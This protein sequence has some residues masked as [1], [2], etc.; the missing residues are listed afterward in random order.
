MSRKRPKSVF[1]MER[2]RTACVGVEKLK[3]GAPRGRPEG[4]S[5]VTQP[6]SPGPFAP[7]SVVAKQIQQLNAV[8]LHGY[9]Q[10]TGRMPAKIARPVSASVYLAPMHSAAGAGAAAARAAA[11]RARPERSPEKKRARTAGDASP[12]ALVRRGS[13]DA[14]D[15][16]SRREAALARGDRSA[17]AARAAAAPPQDWEAAAAAL[18]AAREMFSAAARDD[19]RA[20]EA[21]AALS[22][23]RADAAMR[24]VQQ[25][26]VERRGR[27]L[28]L[29]AANKAA[30]AAGD[31]DRVHD[32]LSWAR[33]EAADEGEKGGAG[34]RANAK[35]WALEDGERLR[36]EA[37]AAV[38]RARWAQ[39]R[40]LLEAAAQCFA[41]AKARDLLE[42]AAQCFAWA[43]ARDLLEAAAQCFAWAKAAAQCF[44]WAKAAAQC[45]AWVKA[46]SA[47]A[48]HPGGAQRLS[49]MRRGQY[50]GAARR[51]ESA[52]AAAAP[53][54]DPDFQ[55]TAARFAF[56]MTLY[57][58]ASKQAADVAA[59]Q[60]RVA[61]LQNVSEGQALLDRAAA[62]A[63]LLP[64]ADAIGS[65][66]GGS[67]PDGGGGGGA[68]RLL[69]RAAAAYGTAGDGEGV[70]RFVDARLRTPS[71]A[72]NDGVDRALNMPLP[73]T[74]RAAPSYVA[75]PHCAAA[76]TSGITLSHPPPPPPLPPPLPAASAVRAAER[77]FAAV[78]AALAQRDYRACLAHVELAHASLDHAVR[79]LPCQSP[80]LEHLLGLLS[81][82]LH[83][84]RP[85]PSELVCELALQDGAAAKESPTLHP[86][87]PLPS[88]LVCE[89]AL[90][91]G[92]VA[93]DSEL[94]CELAL[95]DR[96]AAA[97]AEGRL[98]DAARDAAAAT[99]CLAWCAANALHPRPYAPPPLPLLRHAWGLEPPP[100]RTPG[101]AP[102]PPQSPSGGTPAA[103]AAALAAA[104]VTA[105]GLDY[106][107]DEQAAAARAA[108]RRLVRVAA[109][110]AAGATAAAAAGRRGAAAPQGGGALAGVGGG[111]GAR[112]VGAELQ[113]R[114]QALLREMAGV[115][116]EIAQRSALCEADAL[117]EQCSA[118]GGMPRGANPSAADSAAVTAMLEEAER[119][120]ERHGLAH[121]AR[122]AARLR[123]AVGGGACME[124]ARRA[125][126][127]GRAAEALEALAEAEAAYTRAGDAAAA[128]RAVQIALKPAAAAAALHVAGAA[129]AA[130]VRGKRGDMALEGVEAAC[131]ALRFDDALA[132]MEDARALY[133]QALPLPEALDALRALARPADVLRRRA[134]G[135]GAAAKAS[136][137]LALRGDGGGDGGGGGNRAATAAALR[138]RTSPLR[139]TARV[140]AAVRMVEGLREGDC[141]LAQFKED[142]RAGAARQNRGLLLHAERCY[143]DAKTAYEELV[144]RATELMA[145]E[146]GGMRLGLALQD[147]I[148]A[149]YTPLSDLSRAAF[150]EN[151]LAI[152]DAD[153]AIVSA[154]PLVERRLFADA[155]AT[156]AVAAGT[157]RRGVASHGGGAGARLARV[158]RLAAVLLDSTSDPHHL[159]DC[160]R[161]AAGI[162]DISLF[163]ALNGVD[164]AAGG[165]AP[166]AGDSDACSA[167][168]STVASRASECISHGAS[169]C[170]VGELASA[171]AAQVL[172]TSKTAADSTGVD[173]PTHEVPEPLRAVGDLASDARGASFATDDVLPG[174]D[175]H[176]AESAGDLPGTVDAKVLRH[177]ADAGVTAPR[178]SRGSGDYVPDYDAELSEAAA[179]P[180]DPPPEYA[181]S[182]AGAAADAAFHASSADVMASGEHAGSTLN[183]ATA[184][185]ARGSSFGRPARDAS[186]SAQHAGS[187]NAAAAQEGAD[188]PDAYAFEDDMETDAAQRS[189]SAAPYGPPMSGATVDDG[190]A[191]LEGPESSAEPATTT[192]SSNAVTAARVSGHALHGTSSD[193]ASALGTGQQSIVVASSAL[194]REST[195]KRNSA[196]AD[197]RHRA[198]R[199]SSSMAPSAKQRGTRS[200]ASIGIGRLN[201]DQLSDPQ[202]YDALDDGAR[203]PQQSMAGDAAGVEG[204]A[205]VSDYLA[206]V[207]RRLHTGAD[208]DDGDAALERV[209]EDNVQGE[210]A[211]PAA[212]E[213]G[214]DRAQAAATMACGAGYDDDSDPPPPQLMRLEAAESRGMPSTAMATEPEQACTTDSDAD[215]MQAGA[216]EGSTAE[217]AEAAAAHMDGD[218]NWWQ[219]VYHTA[220]TS[221]PPDT[222]AAAAA[223]ARLRS[224]DGA[225]VDATAAAPVASAEPPSDGGCTPSAG[226][227]AAAPAAPA[228]SR[229]GDGWWQQVYHAARESNAPGAA[230]APPSLRMS[231]GALAPSAAPTVPVPPDAAEQEDGGSWWQQVYH[232][233][234]NLRQ[235]LSA[236][237]TAEL[238]SSAVG[239]SVGASA[240]ATSDLT[241]LQEH[242]AATAPPPPD[243]GE[244]PG[245]SDGSSS[246]WQQVY[247]AER[248]SQLHTGPAPR[249]SASARLSDGAPVSTAAALAAAPEAAAE[250]QEGPSM[251]PPAAS[252]IAQ[253]E[254]DGSWWQ[255]VY[256]TERQ[257]RL[258]RTRS[259]P[260]T[261]SAR[262]SA[263]A[264][265]DASTA[266]PAA[267]ESATAQGDD[268]P[269]MM[270][271]APD[272]AQLQE[273][274]ASAWWQQVYHAERQSQLPR[275]GP[276][277][278]QSG[279]AR[280]A[281]GADVDVV[282]PAPAAAAP[283]E[284]ERD[285]GWR[286]QVYHSAQDSSAAASALTTA[287]APP[288]LA[289]A[290]PS[291]GW[292]QQVYDTA[293]TPSLPA[294]ASTSVQIQ[295]S[296][297][298]ADPTV[299][300]STLAGPDA[301]AA[302]TRPSDT[303]PSDATTA[304]PLVSA[305]SHGVD[306]DGH[307]ARQPAPVDAESF[308]AQRSS[309]IKA[310]A[311]DITA[312][313]TG[314]PGT[315]DSGGSWWN[316]VYHAALPASASDGA[317]TGAAAPDRREAA[318]A[319]IP[320]AARESYTSLPP[321]DV[322][323]QEGQWWNDVCQQVRRSSEASVAPFNAELL[324]AVRASGSA[325]STA[326]T[327][328]DVA[329]SAQ[330]SEALGSSSA[331][332]RMASDAH[333][334]AGSVSSG[335]PAEHRHITTQHAPAA[336]ASG[337]GA[338]GGRQS[339]W[340]EQLYATAAPLQAGNRLSTDTISGSTQPRTS[341]GRASVSGP[342]AASAVDAPSALYH[343]HAP[344]S[345]YAT[346]AAAFTA[347]DIEVSLT[348]RALRTEAPAHSA[349]GAP[350]ATVEVAAVVAE[351]ALAAAAGAAPQMA[352]HGADNSGN[353]W[354]Q[355][356]DGVVPTP[357]VPDSAADLA[358][359]SVEVGGTPAVQHLTSAAAE[360]TRRDSLP[361]MPVAQAVDAA[362]GERRSSWWQAVYQQ[363]AA[364]SDS[365]AQRRDSWWNTVYQQSAAAAAAAALE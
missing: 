330:V 298:A 200:S 229:G 364:G 131:A 263:G 339:L 192:L 182:A 250:L 305:Q 47:R 103:A 145:D 268:A 64:A 142:A 313:D 46:S 202:D 186:G 164:A 306:A 267:R 187:A 137:L 26:L 294:A 1:M 181:P 190:A 189:D 286:Q 133:L 111:G 326:A 270:P 78:A 195:A 113:A 116:E 163:T 50:A 13:A 275:T 55:C 208:H 205:D 318:A 274:G 255:Q 277:P 291:G 165:S 89:L 138:R 82:T 356:Y 132:A 321:P 299:R 52:S 57:V 315:G 92:A 346:A 53:E 153:A 86:D 310:P 348:P 196:A 14:V 34:G 242:P 296:D 36:E 300:N 38:A 141:V 343:A 287:P 59:L 87:R 175:L 121:A 71:V 73:P 361:G 261:A 67:A 176:G 276:A 358:S 247:H 215:A 336:A 253:A 167:T 139:S 69:Q 102:S 334:A 84:D 43:K 158:E 271:A 194:A 360:G 129:A 20:A 124:T 58:V 77:C 207:T 331:Y 146:R 338:G 30:R 251:L 281:D 301:T 76:A 93:K 204:G 152:L 106:L 32:L 5:R 8:N 110:A 25:G 9:S 354:A 280:L 31:Y 104:S 15:T 118:A 81:P 41:W 125:A 17:A 203:C 220:R 350:D 95:Q 83:P 136:A 172:S 254:A 140:D 151:S 184:R 72:T 115:R 219:Q 307:G 352:P 201:E 173:E 282:T 130:S 323:A 221:A 39:A 217:D 90:Q 150:V 289:Q 122:R 317:A 230:A 16:L 37:G 235:S 260:A 177:S 290:R 70:A 214:G 60:R 48:A 264:S 237:A 269:S 341:L 257:S 134:A 198:S 241:E 126:A 345:P 363:S 65:G 27:T 288:P 22:R 35:R 63:R 302:A 347:R 161:D 178:H 98:S 365:S 4:L 252:G 314:M 162:P 344:P 180:A 272:P 292:W 44:A 295:P 2:P 10:E 193:E 222:A 135:A 312:P 279:S 284:G 262:P 149:L 353:W 143:G 340:W 357:L 332:D 243:S 185:S 283:S 325:H 28:P 144:R 105:D 120:Y 259:E 99:A 328:A 54:S 21:G 148:N 320:T 246:W 156:I 23:L 197:A 154:L 359:D 228:E 75:R 209:A 329:A 123:S 62:H 169:P 45:F 238:R 85:L 112:R 109:A 68:A 206:A 351:P 179:D 157:Y 159:Q 42:A 337:D 342:R 74:R 174:A 223:A 308:A 170:A 324:G 80:A 51:R 107:P 265:L 188:E 234:R 231:D 349:A 245:E 225:C 56:P 327:T 91:D 160:V 309:I 285:G 239:A 97:M 12:Y 226:A 355:V 244:L 88:E 213:A 171:A 249:Q 166:Y 96:C 101:A 155:S 212:E 18:G 322:A 216:G 108:L 258:S 297:S 183:D 100:D 293:L 29:D 117:M 273:N 303:T 61:V 256:H 333:A 191:E 240:T 147:H 316:Q 232:T 11:L 19:A 211:V 66:G 362:A 210:C 236:A 6:V 79:A 248:Q 119:L 311:P 335:L 128:A 278:R 114:A 94:V 227:M 319:V 233:D 224:S 168:T 33:R 127:Q 266:A 199:G 218:G 7:S 3:L 40:D 304:A 24:A 49:V